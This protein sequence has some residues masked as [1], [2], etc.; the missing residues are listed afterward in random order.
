MAE[1]S[2]DVPS[3]KHPAHGVHCDIAGNTIVFLTVCAA[4]RERWLGTRAVHEALVSV[5]KSARAWL[6]GG[7]VIMPDHLHLFAV[8]GE[9]ELPL[10]NWVRYWKSQYSKHFATEGQAWQVDHWDRRLRREEH[11][12]DAWEYVRQ[13]P[14]RAGLVANPDAWPFQGVLHEF[15]WD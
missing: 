3:R 5:W 7:Y 8:P 4:K 13:N 6:V 1:L 14:V 15:R 2:P 10:D 11:Y 9:I 12:D